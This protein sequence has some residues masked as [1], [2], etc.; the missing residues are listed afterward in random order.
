MA[1]EI[2]ILLTGGH[3][4]TT[5]LAVIEEIK[6]RYP[7]AEI[8]WVGSKYAVS[9][10]GALTLEYKIYPSIGVKFYEINA[11]KLQT[12]FTRYTILHFLKI[13]IGFFQGL[14]LILKIKPKVIFSLGG[15]ASFPIVFWG[16]AFN[17]PVIIHEQTVAA[18]RASIF[19]SFIVNKIALA[20]VESA[21]YFPRW[22][23][24]V[25]GNP[26][27]PN[28]LSVKP[29]TLRAIGPTGRRPFNLLVVGG[30]RGSEFINEEIIKIVSELSKKYK[31]IHITGERNFDKYK[32]HKT[33]NYQPISF[34]DP[35]EMY[36]YYQKADIIIARSGANTV[37]EVLYIKR[38]TIFIPLPRTYANEQFKNAKYAE[39]F[40]IAKVMRE[41]EVTSKSLL[42]AINEMSQNYSKFIANVS[43][44]ESPDVN[45]S[46]K[47]VDIIAKYL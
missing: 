45:A 24:I 37:S 3:A 15:F 30:S 13:P 46:Q 20:R 18:G 10:S 11:G 16:S 47:V 32:N 34:V 39:N 40:G 9:G 5:G 2:K 23:V 29:I 6:K 1:K 27:M 25:T 12:K 19:S 43:N 21:K 31:I 4:A 7:S 22:K 33:L 8:S 36:K 44:N 26:L 41:E 38:P 35:R 14:Y 28:I 42:S 17:I